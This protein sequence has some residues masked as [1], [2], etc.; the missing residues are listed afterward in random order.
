MK[1]DFSRLTW[2][3]R[4]HYAA[5]LMQQ[6]RLQVD[7]DWNEQIDIIMHRLETEVADYVGHSG[8]PARAPTGFKVTPAPDAAHRERPALVVAPGRIYVEGRLFETEEPV[9]VDL[10][11]LFPSDLDPTGPARLVAY[12]DTWQRHV[13][14]AED[15][16]I[17]EVALGGPDTATRVQNAWRLR[18]ATAAADTE[19][20]SV[21][22]GWRPALPS[23]STGMMNARVT[24]DVPA[25][26]NQLYRI[27]IH[28]T[29]D[30]GVRFTWS[31]DNGSVVATITDVQPATRTLSVEGGG[32]DGDAALA[33]RQWVELLTLEQLSTGERGPVVQLERIGGGQVAVSE[34]T[35]PWGAEPAPPIRALRRWDDPSGL[36]TAT[37]VR[38][39]EDGG[40]VPLENG[41]E[42][43]FEPADDGGATFVPGD[44]WLVPARAATASIEWPTGP[45]GD[46]AAQGARGVQHRYAALALL[47]RDGEGTWS[48][49][50]GGDLRTLVSPLDDGFVSKGAA[51]DVVRGPLSIQPAL[52]AVEDGEDLIALRVAPVFDDNGRSAVN[53]T[54]LRVTGGAVTFGAEDQPI[55]TVA[56]GWLSVLGTANARQLNVNTTATIGGSLTVTG[57]PADE[58]GWALRIGDGPAAF[59]LAMGSDT[60]DGYLRFGGRRFHLARARDGLDGP[61]NTDS[62]GAVLTVT[63]AGLVGV[64]TRAPLPL[65]ALQV[66]AANGRAPLAMTSLFNLSVTAK[67]M[68]SSARPNTLLIA[69]Q[70][71]GGDPTRIYLYWKDRDGMIWGTAL[72]KDDAVTTELRHEGRQSF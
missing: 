69:G 54:A 23:I 36:L 28:S 44:F 1:G 20:A 9:T 25:L 72:T 10:T 43:R 33:E 38:S 47:D 49:V 29:P 27:E 50:D 67:S 45:R 64:N 65:A 68:N 39:G 24:G 71:Q 13:T 22:V 26:E 57:Q 30:G 46:P 34:E 61:L 16:S 42:I 19:P 32:R 12:L 48:V 15:P 51:G 17:R 31:R 11:E 66:T 18:L 8:V 21:G 56:Y 14:F 37:V 63:D 55:S 40:W 70:M 4:K 58:V 5:V 7:A 35:W 2:D 60:D 3:R 52:R 59:G 6:G 62:S 41:I 53:H